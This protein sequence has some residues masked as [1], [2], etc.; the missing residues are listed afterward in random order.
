M[1][2][3]NVEKKLEAQAKA[4]NTIRA[5]LKAKMLA[6]GPNNFIE[7]DFS[8]ML[9]LS[10]PVNL[11]SLI[12]EVEAE[13]SQRDTKEETG[14]AATAGYS[15]TSQELKAEPDH[16]AHLRLQDAVKRAEP[17]F[18]DVV[19]PV[20]D[21]L[22][23]N[24]CPHVKVLIDN[25]GGELLGGLEGVFFEQETDFEPIVTR[26]NVKAG[27]FV[28]VTSWKGGRDRSYIGELFEIKHVAGAML[29]VERHSKWK[30]DHGD[31]MKLNLDEVNLE[32]AT[33]EFLDGYQWLREDKAA[34]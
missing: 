9:W 31:R 24:H 5:S 13:L 28:T 3:T 33:K 1:K 30:H 7:S 12:G 32:R 2:D 4:D 18:E 25:D 22:R 26:D 17:S 19:K 15:H 14:L 11:A 29:F 20:V 6:A 21:Y 23:A 34:A 16:A 10:N 8:E 27:E